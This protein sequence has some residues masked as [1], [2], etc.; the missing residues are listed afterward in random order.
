MAFAPQHRPIEQYRVVALRRH[1]RD[2]VEA[3]SR[4]SDTARRHHL[5]QL[6]VSFARTAE[7]VEAEA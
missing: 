5:L 6:A 2:L 1:V 3:A 7:A 4:E